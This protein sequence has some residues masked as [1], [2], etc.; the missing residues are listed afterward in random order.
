[1]PMTSFYTRCMETAQRET[2]GVTIAADPN[3]PKGDFIFTELYCDD[4]ECECSRVIFCVQPRGDLSTILATLN[5]G[6]ESAAYYAAWSHDENLAEEMA[7][8]TLEPF[9]QQTKYSEGFFRLAQEIL[10]ADPAYIQR[11]KRH[12]AEFRATLPAGKKL[13]GNAGGRKRRRN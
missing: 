12:Y 4:P 9:G 1:M 6:W 10:I 13:R 8:L 7:T 5:F 11:L 2:R 3:L